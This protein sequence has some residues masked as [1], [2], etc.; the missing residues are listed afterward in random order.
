MQ[1]KKKTKLNKRPLLSEERWRDKSC[2]D[3]RD[4]LDWKGILINNKT[5]QLPKKWVFLFSDCWLVESV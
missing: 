4:I 5:F 2:I 1:K 3:P